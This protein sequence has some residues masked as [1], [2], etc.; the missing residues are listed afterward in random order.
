[1]SKVYNYKLLDKADKAA[2]TR[3][4][5][6]KARK[7]RGKNTMINRIENESIV[8]RGSKQYE[9]AELL[10]A[11]D[12]EA[13]ILKNGKTPL[14]WYPVARGEIYVS[15]L[16][17]GEVYTNDQLAHVLEV[18]LS[19]S[20]EDEVAHEIWH[21]FYEQAFLHTDVL[22]LRAFA[23]SE[24]K[25]AKHT[26]REQ[27]YKAFLALTKYFGNG[28]AILCNECYSRLNAE[29]IA[30]YSYQWQHSGDMYCGRHETRVKFL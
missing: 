2:S 17:K 7:Y 14:L 15:W 23:R 5:V 29:E 16:Q 19:T 25:R 12:S 6:V 24:V 28:T 21:A 11:F 26:E 18:W 1:M 4:Y 27:H 13:F 3:H 9:R 20:C 22:I 8:V 30:R 10:A